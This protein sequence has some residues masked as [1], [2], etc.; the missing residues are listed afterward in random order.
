MGAPAAPPAAAAARPVEAPERGELDTPPPGA[1][2]H[3]GMRSGGSQGCCA[4]GARSSAAAGAPAPL[5]LTPPSPGGD[6]RSG[7]SDH[8][9]RFS[10]RFSSSSDARCG[11][12]S[13]A[14][15]A[16]A[17]SVRCGPRKAGAGGGAGAGASGAHGGAGAAAAEE[18]GARGAAGAAMDVL[19]A[20][21]D[22]SGGVGSATAAAAAATAAATA[23]SDGGAPGPI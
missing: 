18:A 21:V 7:G 14:R 9:L 12:T 16:E 22:G 5:G 10:P 17:A 6:A 4:I 2:P 13:G 20:A 23:S 8:A 19:A 15:P 3:S 1:A 11:L